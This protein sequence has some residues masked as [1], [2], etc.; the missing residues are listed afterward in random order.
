MSDA[1]RR[2]AVGLRVHGHARLAEQ[3]EREAAKLEAENAEL[4]A[5]LAKHAKSG[6]RH[7]ME[8]ISEDCWCAGWLSGMEYDLWSMVQGGPRD[9]GVSEVSQGEVGQLIALSQQTGGWWHRPKGADD[10]VSISLDDWKALFASRS[11]ASI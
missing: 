11:Q 9:Y 5:A 7:L 4:R 1:L 2:I 3:I 6:L 8:E 10:A